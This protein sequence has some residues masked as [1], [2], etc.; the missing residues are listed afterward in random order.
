M[1]PFPHA[2]I[3]TT[4]SIRLLLFLSLLLVKAKEKVSFEKM[5][6]WLMGIFGSM[7]VLI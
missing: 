2:G 3:R 4:A 5:N 6:I 1:D 7:I